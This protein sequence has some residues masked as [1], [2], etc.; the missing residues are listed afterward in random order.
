[1][2]ISSPESYGPPTEQLMFPKLVKLFTLPFF[3]SLSPAKRVMFKSS[4]VRLKIPISKGKWSDVSLGK[5][6]SSIYDS[7]PDGFST[8]YVFSVRLSCFS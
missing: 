5:S 4:Q 8:L 3:S 1:M 2:G 7:T 6:G